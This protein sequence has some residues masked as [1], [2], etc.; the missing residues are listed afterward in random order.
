MCFG[1]VLSILDKRYRRKH[2]KKI[3]SSARTESSAIGVGPV[4]TATI[5]ASKVSEA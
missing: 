3:V 1:G 4:N 2:T 5:N